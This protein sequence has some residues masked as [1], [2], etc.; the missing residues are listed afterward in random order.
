MTVIPFRRGTRGHKQCRRCDEKHR[1]SEFPRD[2][3]TGRPTT[4]CK[5]CVARARRESHAANGTHPG[6]T[7][8][9]S[10]ESPAALR[11]A[12]SRFFA[13]TCTC[14]CPLNAH[15]EDGKSPCVVC[16]RL[17]CPSYFEAGL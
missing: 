6:R 15:G 11:G 5:D 8:G 14:T 4:V 9:W 2:F 13:G 12:A 17:K 1:P 10:R 3:R 7:N 16:G